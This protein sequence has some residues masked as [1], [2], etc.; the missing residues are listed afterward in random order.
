[1]SQAALQSVI[2]PGRGPFT[3]TCGQAI[4]INSDRQM[5]EHLNGSRHRLGAQP[6]HQSAAGP[7]AVPQPGPPRPPNPTPSTTAGQPASRPNEVRC[8]VCHI[9]L[10]NMDAYDAHRLGPQHQRVLAELASGTVPSAR[11][12]TCTV[13]ERDVPVVRWDT[14]VTEDQYHKRRQRFA[15]I[16]AETEQNRNGIVVSGVGGSGVD[17]GIVEVDAVS[18]VSP[19]RTLEVT[20]INEIRGSLITLARVAFSSSLR[21]SAQSSNF[22]AVLRGT[23][24]FV[25]HGRPCAVRVTFH[26]SYV[27]R[28]QD[29]LELEFHDLKTS[30]RFTIVRRVSATVG[31]ASVHTLLAARG[32]YVRLPFAPR[33]PDP[34]AI[35]TARPPTWTKVRWAVRMGEYPIPEAMDE[36]FKK[37]PRRSLIGEIRS[38]FMPNAFGSATYGKHFQALLHLEEIQQSADLARFNMFD[39]PIR[40]EAPRYRLPIPGLAEGKPSVIVGDTIFLKQAGDNNETWYEGI[41]HKI[42][43]SEVTLQVNPK[44]KLGGNLRGSVDV[45]FKLNRVPLR[46]AHQTITM[47]NNPPR[48]LF[49][50]SHDLAGLQRVSRAQI[51][52]LVLENNMLIDNDEQM[53][54]IAAIVTMPPGSVPFVVFGPPGTGKTVTIVEAI[55]Q[56]L[57]RNPEARI[58]ACA[59]GNKAADLIAERL[60]DLGPAQ[61]FRLNAMSRKYRELSESVVLDFSLVND[62]QV[63]A[64][65]E[66]SVLKSFRVV[67]ATCVSAGVPYGLGVELGWFSHIFI[68]EAGQGMEP[69]VMVPIKTMA[70]AR[71]NVILAGDMKQ[72]GPVVRSSYARELGLKTS[73]LERLI[74]RPTHDLSTS[75]GLTIMKL[76]KHWRSHPGIINFANREFYNN[77]LQP[78]G[79]PVVTHR[80]LRSE[81]L[82]SKKFP[83][84]FHSVTGRDEQEEGSPSYF[85]IDEAFLVRK[86]CEQLVTDRKVPIKP[87]EIGIISPYSGQC[88]KIRQL[89]GRSDCK[90]EGLKVG[91][92]EEFQGAERVAIIIST[93]RSRSRNLLQDLRHDLGFVGNGRRLNVA[94]TRARSLLIVVGDPNILGLDPTWRQFLQYVQVNGGW[95]GRP[96]NFDAYASEEEYASASRN[97]ADRE[98]QEMIERLRSMIVAKQVAD[99]WEVPEPDGL[100]V[101]DGEAYMDRPHVEGD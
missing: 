79:D 30:T 53:Q 25:S 85:N 13:C 66:L 74:S 21:K 93:V 63:F 1:M 99:G 6:T 35:P 77:E 101:D 64:I 97:E 60:A 98:A 92:V 61:L 50:E 70:D 81:T 40:Y 27:G 56:I 88:G 78:S 29:I 23:S 69:E 86:Y 75:R 31:S 87:H 73:F 11:V 32:R 55:F 45:R 20:V 72:L 26:P 46:R 7:S 83:V 58:L 2:D 43:T 8:D 15:D 16:T 17:F 38:R 22:S 71:T 12:L 18:S 68:D 54:T 76:L 33:L 47:P 44:F 91:P 41:I 80:M 10:D 96:A 5:Q 89:L 37:P 4:K 65:P 36:L 57:K 24:K 94:I 90:L 62:N 95:R 59:Q 49:P 52:D 82:V 84:V 39:M 51:D 28:F 9:L 3:C 34:R 14:H 19:E 100:D 42:Y 67:V 48:I